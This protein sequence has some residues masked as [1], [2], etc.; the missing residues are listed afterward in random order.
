[1]FFGVEKIIAYLSTITPLL[2]GDVI[3]TGSPEGTGATQKPPRF[4]RSGDR[5]EFEVS[6]L[7]ILSN[8][9]A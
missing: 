1:M 5:L 3:A 7:G 2:P 6:G 9:V 8:T 4:L